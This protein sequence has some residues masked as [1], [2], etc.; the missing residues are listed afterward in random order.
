MVRS[1]RVSKLDIIKMNLLISPWRGISRWTPGCF[2]RLLRPFEAG[3]FSEA[4][5]LLRP[6]YGHFEAG[7][8][9]PH[10]AS[11]MRLEAG[12]IEASVM[13]L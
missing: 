3:G 9:R 8:W 12:F 13:R 11:F 4:L 7:I 5:R 10:E 2:M 1:C 6:A